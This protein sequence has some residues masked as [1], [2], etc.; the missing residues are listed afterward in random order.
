[1][2]NL[3]EQ[4]WSRQGA[5]C[6]TAILLCWTV[7]GLRPALGAQKTATSP[8]KPAEQ[9]TELDAQRG[10]LDRFLDS[11]PEIE[12]EILG[13]PQKIS[14]PN[15]LHQ[16]PGLQ[17]FLD[18]HP[19]VKADPRAFVM[20]GGAR[21]PQ[22]QS[23]TEGLLDYVVPFS[24]F[25]C[26]LLAILWV[27]RTLL[28]NR[29]WNKSFRVHEDVHTKL[30]EKFA[31]AQELTAYIESEAGRRLLEWT[32]PSLEH[33]TP[34]AASRILGSLQAGLIL[35]LTGAGLL[36]VRLRIPQAAEPLL[37]FGVLGLTIGLG[38][39]LSAIISY[40]IS[41]HMGLL[42]AGTED[43]ITRRSIAG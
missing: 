22:R 43:R 23:A 1:M 35:G 10:A 32:P 18:G 6:L 31:T 17:A 19:L 39:L 26:A 40:G 9:E 24:V 29:R 21:F 38:F 14:D 30:I 34:F 8:V 25:L 11:H 4:Q 41:R 13:D 33:R 20:S 15:Y 37:L 36:S 5:W 27:V 3:V 2:T 7:A 12:G 42:T 16:H 28:E